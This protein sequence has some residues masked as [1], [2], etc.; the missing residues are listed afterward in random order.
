MRK[1]LEL[2]IFV[3]FLAF[4][5]IQGGIAQ[6]EVSGN[7]TSDTT[8]T[9]AGSPYIVTGDYFHLEELQFWANWNLFLAQL[10]IIIILRDC[11]HGGRF[12]LKPGDYGL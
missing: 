4:L 2:V 12:G 8:W 3:F 5:R 7:I 11:Y 1:L 6:T 9:K 10:L